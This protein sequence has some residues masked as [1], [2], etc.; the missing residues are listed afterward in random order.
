MTSIVYPLGYGSRLDNLELRYSL[1]SIEKFVTGF[2]KIF[3]IGQKPDFL[4]WSERLIH[5]P[6]EDKHYSGFLNTWLKM[7]EVAITAEVSE[8]FLFMND[9][10]FIVKEMEATEFPMYSSG[11][12]LTERDFFTIPISEIQTRYH[13]TLRSTGESLVSRELTTYNFAT[14][15]PCIFE[16]AKILELFREFAN[17]IWGIG[18]SF[19]CCYGNFFKFPRMNNQAVVMKNAVRN[20]HGRESFALCGSSEYKFASKFLQSLYP[21]ESSFE[22]K[23]IEV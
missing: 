8:N 18:L 14:H 6:F 23:E 10:F 22:L 3:I 4:N 21:Q 15:Q 5:I 12:D 11:V 20:V 1:R 2:E 13:Q 17:E 19:R 9:D 16:K 7:R